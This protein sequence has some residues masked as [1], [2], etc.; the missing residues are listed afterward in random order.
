MKYFEIATGYTSIPAKIGAATEKDVEGQ[1]KSMVKM[2]YDV[3]IVDI[4]DKHRAPTDLPII[5]VWM[6]QFFNSNKVV[7]LGFIHKLK[8][9]LYSLSLTNKL[10]K[11][12]KNSNQ[13]IYLHFHNQYNMFFFMKLTR[14]SLLKNVSIGYTVHSYIWYG[15]F[16][17]IKDTIRKR[18][19]QEVYCCHKAD[20]VFVLNDVVTK[21][22]VENYNINKEKIRKIFNGV[23]TD[24]YDEKIVKSS[25]IDKTKAI[26]GLSNYNVILQVGSIC[27]RKNQLLSLELLLPI[28]KKRE[29]IAFAYAGGIINIEYAE[30]IQNLAK[31]NGL[32]NRVIYCGEVSPGHDL[33]ILYAMSKFTIFNSSAEAYGLVITESLSVSRPVFVNEHLIESISYW[34]ENEGLGIIRIGEDFEQNV[35]RLLDDNDYY[36]EMKIKSRKVAYDKLSWDA[37]TRLHMKYM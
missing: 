6:P 14:K 3:S 33:N 23:D 11:L 13:E 28:L 8:R 29:D 2:G 25:D 37:A 12:I 15:K 32:E 5:D 30:E 22:L 19:F 20:R 34:K 10:H 31:K 27:P 36:Q 21:M 24:V 18:Y 35:N 16:E 7:S 1:T 17:D 9:V 26:Y 4:R